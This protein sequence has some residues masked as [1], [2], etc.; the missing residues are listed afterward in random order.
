MTT[1]SKRSG[2]KFV[3]LTYDTLTIHTVDGS[4]FEVPPQP[5]VANVVVRK[6]CAGV[7][8]GVA[9]FGRSYDPVDGLPDEDGDEVAYIVSDHVRTAVPWRR[10]VFSPGELIFEGGKAVGHRG[11]VGNLQ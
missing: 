4:F 2:V 1:I 7:I 3:N 8:N 9:V 6:Q 11:L 10:D 5:Y